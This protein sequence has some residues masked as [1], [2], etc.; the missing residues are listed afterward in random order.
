MWH[1]V[2]TETKV[3]RELAIDAPVVLNIRGPRHVVPLAFILHSKFL[4]A[5][6]I[7]EKEIGEVVAG[8]GTVEIEATLRLAEEILAL[9]VE[10]PT[11][12]DFDLMSAFC[13]RE[14]VTELIVVGLVGPR[15]AGDF[16]LG[17]G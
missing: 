3:E 16:E 2:P 4:V 9:L 11:E 8:E 17:A 6:G 15:P 14:I 1:T 12:T 7:A 5:L 10:R 13:D